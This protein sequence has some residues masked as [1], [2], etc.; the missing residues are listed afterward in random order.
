MLVRLIHSTLS[1]EIFHA[2]QPESYNKN[3][4]FQITKF[5]HRKISVNEIIP[6]ENAHYCPIFENPTK[7]E[8]A[9]CFLHLH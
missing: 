6:T 7:A 4:N 9:K 5:S 1:M 3:N 2:R 8:T